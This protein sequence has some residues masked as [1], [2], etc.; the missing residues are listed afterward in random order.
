MDRIGRPAQ[1]GLEPFL[2]L[3]I[4][5]AGQILAFQFEQVEGMVGELVTGGLRAVAALEHRLQP[6]EVGVALGIRRND[7]AV[8]QAAG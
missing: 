2:A 1:Q 3:D 7:L 4:G 8:D 6:R 5:Q